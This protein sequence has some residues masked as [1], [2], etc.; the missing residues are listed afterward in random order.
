MAYCCL[1]CGNEFE[2]KDKGHLKRNP[3]KYCSHQCGKYAR[4][5][6]VTLQCSVCHCEFQRKKYMEHWSL[7]RGPFC[8]FQCYAK[9]QS[10]NTRGEENPNY[11]P[12]AWL[13]R[14]CFYCGKGVTRRKLDQRDSYNWYCSTTCYREY[15]QSQ[16]PKLAY[17]WA[18]KRWHRAR[19]AAL[20]R[21]QGRCSLCKSTSDLVVHHVRPFAEFQGSPD[22]HELGNLQTVCRACHRRLHNQ[23]LPSRR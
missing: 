19:Q 7:E 17:R 4:L 20:D 10:E 13:T 11:Q 6:L 5:S 3:P 22:A 18:S 1:R 23:M 15:Q 16:Y 21:D 9:W 8:G 2:P 12:E 14:P